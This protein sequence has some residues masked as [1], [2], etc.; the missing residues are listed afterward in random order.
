M[1]YR[2][3]LFRRGFLRRVSGRYPEGNPDGGAECGR[4][5]A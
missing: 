5:V 1:G 3:D 2:R 4:P